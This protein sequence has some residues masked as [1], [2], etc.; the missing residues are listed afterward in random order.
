MILILVTKSASRLELIVISAQLG[1][2]VRVGLLQRD[3]LVKVPKEP[4]KNYSLLK[5][6][7]VK[8]NKKP[9][10]NHSLLKAGMIIFID[11]I[12]FSPI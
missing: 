2:D 10:E 7:M 3:C 6:G 1:E 8:V 12:N 11:K 5:A 9:V 4:I